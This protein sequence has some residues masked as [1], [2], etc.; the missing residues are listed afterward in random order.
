MSFIKTSLFTGFIVL[1]ILSLN[2]NCIAYEPQENDKPIKTDYENVD[3]FIECSWGVNDNMQQVNVKDKSD[4]NNP[5]LIVIKRD[6][7]HQEIFLI[8]GIV[9]RIFDHN[10]HKLL[11]TYIGKN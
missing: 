9:V 1:F 5:H 10:N 6:G 4:S 3:V 8:K 7:T 2:I 11:K